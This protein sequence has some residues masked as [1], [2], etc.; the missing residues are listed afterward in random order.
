MEI[1]NPNLGHCALKYVLESDC[2]DFLASPAAYTRDRAL[3]VDWP[4]MAPIESVQL[5]DKLWFVEAD[6]RTCLTRCLKDSMPF[7]V[8]E[9]K[10]YE[11]SVWKGPET[12]E[13]SVDAMGKVFA[14]ALTHHTA[15]WWF[16]M[17]AGWYDHPEIMGFINSAA[18]IYRKAMLENG[19]PSS[20]QIAVIVDEVS[21]TLFPSV[22]GEIQK[23]F[24]QQRIELGF[25]GTPYDTYLFSDLQSIPVEK[26]R[27]VIF[28]NTAYI[29]D[30]MHR[31]LKRRYARDG[32]TLVW[33]GVNRPPDEGDTGYCL[34][35]LTGQPEP[36]FL[37]P[38]GS[39]Y[40]VL[41][42]GADGSPSLV[43][44]K[45]DG[46]SEVISTIPW[47]SAETLREMAILSGVHIYCHTGDIVYSGN[48]CVAVHASS[49]GQKR[50][51]FPSRSSGECIWGGGGAITG[52]FY[53]DFKMSPGQ[54]VIWHITPDG[55]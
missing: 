17:W 19:A 49:D 13:H 21:H 14:H 1:A 33:L 31:E 47:L 32:R 53:H 42:S 15:L 27:M 37:P 18:D 29:S 25:M 7:A 9:N 26:Y 48:S 39:A 36:V 4:P 51:Y 40:Y 16:D 50:I 23:A 20:A 6:V 44:L 3:G 8:P 45:K 24:S 41:R 22:S 35:M 55:E 38:E 52:E 12:L 43:L 2:V 11:A 5:H 34:Y 46:W 54:T 30:D 28:L 10:S